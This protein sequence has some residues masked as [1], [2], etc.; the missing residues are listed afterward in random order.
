MKRAIIVGAAALTVLAVAPTVL[1]PPARAQTIMIEPAQRTR[2]KEYIVQQHVPA[3]R[4]REHVAVG[5]VLPED[6]D[7]VAVPETWGPGVARYRYIYTGDNV[8]LVDPTTRR[9]LQIV[10]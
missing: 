4:I 7:L 3:A 2:I 10:E 8:V 6:V 5:T 1:P 9:V